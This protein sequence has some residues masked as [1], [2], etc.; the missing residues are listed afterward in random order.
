M[1][2]KTKTKKV[3]VVEENKYPVSGLKRDAETA[4]MYSYGEIKILTPAEYDAILNVIPQPR[5][6]ALFTIC[7]VT[8]MRYIEIQRLWD[9]P[10]WYIEARNIIHLPP[11]AQRK[12]KRTQ[13]ERTIKPL[14][15]MFSY[16]L[17]EF[18]NHRRPPT[19]ASWGRDLKKW[20]VMAGLHPYGI[21]AK[22]TRKTIESWLVVA[23]V[24]ESTICMR[25]GHNE[26]TSVHHY[27]NLAFSDIEIMQIK[28]KLTE[29]G[30][31]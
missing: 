15:S 10:K 11:E 19:E 13:L 30:L 24:V 21:S 25:A 18:W 20:A 14:P 26:I 12:A 2:A 6:K 27:Q 3:T 31:K 8:G 22:T 16:I 4:H 28:K 7:V 9:N 29:W 1:I 5:H 17:N 23:G